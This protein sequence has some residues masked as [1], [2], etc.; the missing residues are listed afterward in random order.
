M[1]SGS[2][3]VLLEN[4]GPPYVWRLTADAVGLRL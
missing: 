4:V 2:K 3:K 1:R